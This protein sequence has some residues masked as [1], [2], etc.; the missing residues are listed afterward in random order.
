MVLQVELF[1]D[2]GLVVNFINGGLAR[3]VQLEAIHEA[4]VLCCFWILL[5]KAQLL[6]PYRGQLLE[7]GV[8]LG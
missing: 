6:K 2:D 4:I 8:L 5:D 3:L 1:L 7:G